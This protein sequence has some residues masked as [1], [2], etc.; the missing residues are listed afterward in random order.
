LVFFAELVDRGDVVGGKGAIIAGCRSR[1]GRLW[2]AGRRRWR[3]RRGSLCGSSRRLDHGWEAIDVVDEIDIDLSR[4]GR[5]VFFR[6]GIFWNRSCRQRGL[7]EGL[8]LRIVGHVVVVG[9]QRL[10]KDDS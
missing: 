3:G 7:G 6:K 10:S 2:R 8:G 4:S 5:D 1:R 9:E